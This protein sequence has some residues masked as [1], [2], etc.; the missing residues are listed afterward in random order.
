MT[1]SDEHRRFMRSAP[2]KRV[3][4]HA[5]VAVLLAA[6]ALFFAA[7]PN[8]SAVCFEYNVLGKE[9]GVGNTCAT[10][11]PAL[12]ATLGARE[13]SVNTASVF[14]A[15]G[16]FFSRV[17]PRRPSPPPAA[18]PQAAPSPS[19]ASKTK[20]T[21]G[22][23]TGLGASGQ[24]QFGGGGIF[25]S[26]PIA[27]VCSP[28]LSASTKRIFKGERVVLSWNSGFIL[29][30][31]SSGPSMFLSWQSGVKPPTTIG[32]SSYYFENLFI[33][34]VTSQQVSPSA[35][36]SI[37]VAPTKTTTY[38]ATCTV[39]GGIAGAFTSVKNSASITITV[40]PPVSGT[41]S[42]SP[43]SLTTGGSS[44]WAATPSGGDGTYTYSWSG[45]DGLS[46]S[47]KNVTKTYTSIGTKTASV[48]ISSA[49]SSKVA[50]CANSVTVSAPP[51]ALLSLSPTP[52]VAIPGEPVLLSWSAINVKA[53]SCSISGDN[54]DF[55]TLSGASGTKTS[56]PLFGPATF[57][58]SCIDLAGDAVSETVNI[59]VEA[60]PGDEEVFLI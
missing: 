10:A 2:R 28:S 54:G 14:S 31:I 5:L 49:G 11:A 17:F 60:P 21:A 45:T 33:P 39:T 4:R 22:G 30:S 6:G 35:S 55:F 38:V 52:F 59:S 56:S 9:Y 37:S 58:I 23:T 50:Q 20:S 12:A 42:A 57:T 26:L 29:G 44:T 25:G 8:A 34:P 27:P 19:A 16:D 18:R 24:V 47:T 41:C 46:G 43:T 40:L 15:F 7:P 32:R 36:G 1:V 51:S 53:D 3:S 48:T 13:A